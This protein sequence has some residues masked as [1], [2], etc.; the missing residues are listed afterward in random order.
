MFHE[1]KIVNC[2]F[3]LPDIPVISIG[4]VFV[5][6]IILLVYWGLWYNPK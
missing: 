3:G 5:I 1:K 4:S 2:M 6:I